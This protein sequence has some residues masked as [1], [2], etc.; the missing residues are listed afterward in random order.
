MKEFQA[1]IAYKHEETDRLLLAPLDRTG[2][3][4]YE[5]KLGLQL[6][7]YS[8][9][10]QPS[11]TVQKATK[12]LRIFFDIIWCYSQIRG[13][14]KVYSIRVLFQHCVVMPC[15]NPGLVGDSC[16]RGS[17]FVSQHRILDFSHQYVAKL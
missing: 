3:D 1:G 11:I 17:E 13:G 9:E 16:T 12:F 15:W 8:C 2:N 6:D 10:L 4:W 14:Y 5:S 7:Y